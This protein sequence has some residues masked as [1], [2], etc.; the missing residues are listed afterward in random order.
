MSRADEEA[1][2]AELQRERDALAQRQ[3]ERDARRAAE[4]AADNNTKKGK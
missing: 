1:R 4:D 3:S 2:R